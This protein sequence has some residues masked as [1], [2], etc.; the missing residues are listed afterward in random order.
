MDLHQVQGHLLDRRAQTDALDRL[1]AAFD[2]YLDP[3]ARHT[4]RERETK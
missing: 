4:L 1:L 2:E 3:L